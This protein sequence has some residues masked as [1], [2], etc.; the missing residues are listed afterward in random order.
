MDYETINDAKSFLTTGKGE[1]VPDAWIKKVQKEKTGK[2][3]HGYAMLAR[4]VDFCSFNQPLVTAVDQINRISSLGAVG[5]PQ[6]KHMRKPQDFLTEMARYFEYNMEL[7][8]KLQEVTA[9]DDKH[10]GE[11]RQ[12]RSR[13]DDAK[14]EAKHYKSCQDELTKK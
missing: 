14:G 2:I 6:G 12:M 8:Q 3:Q 10:Q 4:T 11:M 9:R 5:V 13:L 1:M 7:Q